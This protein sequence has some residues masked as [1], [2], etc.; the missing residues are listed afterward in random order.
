MKHSATTLVVLAAGR[1]SRFGGPK[2]FT[3]FGSLEWPLMLYNILHAWQNGISHLVI[4]TRAEHQSV[5]QK[6]VLSALPKGL[7]VDIA[8]QDN[9]NLP[10]S[11]HLPLETEKP[12]G[13]AHALWCAKQY[14]TGCFI[15]IN[16]D[17]Y[18]GAQAFELART[19][20]VEDG[21][22][23][24]Y[25]LC[26][27][28]SEHGGVNRGRCIIKNNKLTNIEEVMG[29]QRNQ[30]QLC[31]GHNAEEQPIQ[32]SEKELVSMNFWIFSNK[33]WSALERAISDTFSQGTYMHKEAHLPKAVSLLISKGADIQ[34][35]TSH[36]AWF[37]VTYAAD[38][39]MVNGKLSDLTA[40]G[41]FQRKV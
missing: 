33:I 13:T 20:T 3:A 9:N 23:V 2:Q 36:D 29:I 4:V 21:A 28:L 15:V 11:C 7:A 16:A 17:D 30:N 41:L 37:G 38:S 10:A 19:L 32:L 26:N 1:G 18:Y 35:L 27:T 14:I 5:L 12:L 31:L 39:P 6:T 40:K 25:Q 34:V 8:F 24:A 22:I